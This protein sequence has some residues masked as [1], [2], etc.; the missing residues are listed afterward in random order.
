MAPEKPSEGSR[1]GS[2]HP[3]RRYLVKL[4]TDPGE[5][6]R[7]IKDPEKSMESAGLSD[8]E[9][10]ILKSGNPAA[11]YGRVAGGPGGAR[12]AYSTPPV[13]VLVVDVHPGPEGEPETLLVR[14]PGGPGYGY[15]EVHPMYPQIH[16]QQVSYPQIHPQ[17]VSYPQ[18]HPQIYHLHPQLLYH[19]HPQLVY[20]PPMIH[21][22]PPPVIHPYHPPVHPQLVYHHP[23]MVYHHPP[24]IHPYHPLVHPQLVYHH[25]PMIYHPHPPPPYGG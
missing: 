24:V 3:L 7:F 1:E 17:Q 25:P 12:E 9:Q 16:P 22:Y 5:L 15:Q 11:I 8:E 2:D 4:A 6:G 10:A 13:T 23:P 20:Q 18:I 21:P 14:G 19:L